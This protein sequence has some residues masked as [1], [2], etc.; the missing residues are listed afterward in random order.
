MHTLSTDSQ[1]ARLITAELICLGVTFRYHKNE[2]SDHV[3]EVEK[4]HSHTLLRLRDMVNGRMERNWT[5][6][7]E[8]MLEVRYSLARGERRRKP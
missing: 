1:R 4:A 2:A 3:I 5:P 6:R 8:E 7:D